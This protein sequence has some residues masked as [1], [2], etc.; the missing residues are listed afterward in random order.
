[1]IAFGQLIEPLF[2]GF[3]RAFMTRKPAKNRRRVMLNGAAARCPMYVF[4]TGLLY[5]AA[6]TNTGY[7]Q[8]TVL[9]TGNDLSPF[10]YAGRSNPVDSIPSDLSPAT[11]ATELR[12]AMPTP[13]NWRNEMPL[14]A[15]I[16]SM[17]AAGIPTCLHESAHDNNLES[18]RRVRLGLHNASIGDNLRF[19]L[20]CFECDF[21]IDISGR[22]M[23]AA[24]DF[25]VENP[26]F[27]T[28]DITHIPADPDEIVE[29]VEETIDPDSWEANGGT[30]RMRTLNSG[31]RTLLTIT[32]TWRNMTR[33]RQLL[34][35]IHGMSRV[36]DVASSNFR[37]LLSGGSTPVELPEYLKP[38][39]LRYGRGYGGREGGGGF[40][41]GVF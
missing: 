37:E 19:M 4:A 31:Q 10:G 18:V 1:M 33:A 9:D 21:T 36:G 28:F 26:L 5:C 29:T 20:D 2:P 39:H 41:G 38:H 24:D 6:I 14:E 17:N 30:G 32:T 15:L 12:I 13:S 27:V 3:E 40:G 11:R 35:S 34:G 16:D 23:I 8:S 25:L 22:I 7:A